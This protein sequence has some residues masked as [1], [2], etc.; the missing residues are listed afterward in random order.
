[1]TETEQLYKE[2]LSYQPLSEEISF[3]LRQKFML[4]FNYNSNHIEGN[5]LTYGQTELLLLFGKV[6]DVAQMKDLEEMKAHNVG[7]KMTIEEAA[8][9]ECQLSETFIRQLH[10]TLLR[11]D[12]EVFREGP[13]G[14]VTS[15]TV[16]AGQYKTRPNSVITATGERFEYASPAE[17]PALMHDLIEWYKEEENK[18]ALSP[19]QLAALFHYRY[20][21]IHPFEDGNGRIARLLANYILFRHNYPMIVI[22]TR[23]KQQYLNA[24]NRC[25]VS[26][27]LIPSVGA[28]ATIEQIQPFV[29]Y[30][31]NCLKLA[32]KTCIKAAKGESI[33]EDDDFDK[34]LAIIERQIQQKEDE[35]KKETTQYNIQKSPERIWDV[36]EYCYFPI[37]KKLEAISAS[38]RRF[39]SYTQVSNILSATERPEGGIHL[40]QSMRGYEEDCTL[41]HAIKEA[42]SIWFKNELRQPTK[43][44]LGN[45]VITQYFKIEFLPDK[46]VIQ[47]KFVFPYDKFPTEDE[48]EDMVGKYKENLLNIIK[49]KIDEAS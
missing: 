30:M 40:N 27:G 49:K 38:M 23:N 26:V 43:D 42:R 12:Y 13:S 4:E 21:R 3:K 17:T 45:L 32:L 2:W 1:M 10:H 46:Y 19:I 25:D 8:N 24:L 28:S 33:E 5:T 47:D 48:K 35:K 20:I 22:K 18:K 11:D 7:L 16:H 31:E 39:F 34:E 37:S 44:C 36:L 29:E 15:Y 9:T 14:V 41:T 6:A